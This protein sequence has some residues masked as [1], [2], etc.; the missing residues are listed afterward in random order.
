MAVKR[1]VVSNMGRT[2][3]IEQNIPAQVENPNM[4]G[5]IL[6]SHRNTMSKTSSEQ[7]ICWITIVDEDVYKVMCSRCAPNWKSM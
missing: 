1:I 3:I 7:S 2:H 4:S 5:S 6:T